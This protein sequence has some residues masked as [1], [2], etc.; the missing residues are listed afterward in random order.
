MTETETKTKT[1]TLYL[2]D[3][4]PITIKIEDWV[5]LAHVDQHDGEVEC[6]ANRTWLLK[7]RRHRKTGDVVVTGHYDSNFRSEP[8]VHAGYLLTDIPQTD[9]LS[10]HMGRVGDAIKQVAEEI[11]EPRLGREAIQDLPAEV[12]PDE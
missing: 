1:K 12:Y 9:P 11:G 8:N 7:V 2:T 6:Q 5:T 10:R 4:P 3:A